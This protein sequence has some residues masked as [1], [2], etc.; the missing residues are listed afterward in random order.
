MS[1]RIHSL[2]SGTV[3]GVGFRFTTK[4][5]AKHFPVT[6]YVKNLDN[7]QVEVVAEGQEADLRVF[8]KHIRESDLATY[9]R[10]VKT[11]WLPAT[12]QY[13]CFDIKT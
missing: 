4:N 8:L 12:G 3:Q 13:R 11:E 9:I 6:G 7:G 5:L 2:F 10:N 1:H